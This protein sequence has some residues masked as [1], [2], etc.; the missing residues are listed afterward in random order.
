MTVHGNARRASALTCY[1]ELVALRVHQSLSYDITAL[2]LYTPS[3]VA[4]VVLA[5][6]P[7]ATKMVYSRRCLKN[8]SRISWASPASLL[9]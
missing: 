8:V 1:L 4:L 3:A 7:Q 6:W 9:A 5:Q 2:G